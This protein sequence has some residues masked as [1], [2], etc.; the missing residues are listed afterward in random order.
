MWILKNAIVGIKLETNFQRIFK[1]AGEV[2]VREK[3]KC[4]ISRTKNMGHAT[5]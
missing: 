5:G 4:F 2:I 3:R 1:T